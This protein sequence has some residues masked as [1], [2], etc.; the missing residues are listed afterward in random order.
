MT[1]RLVY[2]PVSTSKKT[3]SSSSNTTYVPPAPSVNQT[4]TQNLTDDRYDELL[5][6]IND[7]SQKINAFDLSTVKNFAYEMNAHS[8][9]TLLEKSKIDDDNIELA[10]YA[11]I[12]NLRQRIQ[13]I[14]SCQCIHDV[15]SETPV[16]NLIESSFEIPFTFKAENK[17]IPCDVKNYDI[18]VMNNFY[19]P[20]QYKDY[21]QY[22]EAN[23][24]IIISPEILNAPQMEDKLPMLNI[25]LVK[26]SDD[27][28]DH[29]TFTSTDYRIDYYAVK[30]GTYTDNGISY[31]IT[32]GNKIT[33]KFPENITVLSGPCY[34]AN[35][36]SHESIKKAMNINVS[37]DSV[38]W[39]FGVAG[40]KIK[41]EGELNEYYIQVEQKR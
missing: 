21:F 40:G 15:P 2:S 37:A 34:I 22:D 23:K 38:A 27:P 10:I 7:L 1:R 32:G 6:K 8:Y 20:N 36:G 33:V 19:H 26:Y 24:R 25:R 31:I 9:Q 35:D 30:N 12:D 5:A 16:K 4:P 39:L 28:N 41:A 11:E 18:Y 14:S 13:Q 17:Y 29:T 3:T